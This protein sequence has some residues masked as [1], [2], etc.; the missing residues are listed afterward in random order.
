MPKIR[1]LAIPPDTHGV[2]KFRIINPYTYLQ[3]N[4]SDDFHVDINSTIEDK[5]EEFDN[6]DIIVMHT[7]IHNKVSPERNLERIDWLKKQGKT[8]IVDFDDYWEP[9]MRHPMFIQAK[10]GGIVKAK[11][12]I[13]NAADYLTVTTPIY[14]DTI[15][16]KFRLNN[17]VVFPNAIDETEPQFQSNTIPSDKIRFGWLGGSS[18]MSDIELLTNG[19]SNMYNVVPIDKIQFVLCGFDLRGTI[20]EIN[21]QTKEKTSRPI[22]PE[23]TVW[24]K[25]E[26]IFTNN[27]SVLDINYINFLKSFKEI[28][29]DDKDKP[30]IRRW[31]KEISKYATNYNYFDVSLAPLVPNTFNANKSQLKAIEAGFFKKALIASE[32]APYTIDL[33]SAIEFGGKFNPKGN[34]LLVDPNKNHKQWFQYM[35]R[36]VDNPNMIE[37][38]GNKLYETVKDKY[39][40]RKVTEDRV[41]FLKSIIK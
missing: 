37:D 12:E 19:I 35:K 20:T 23:E 11:I 8:V 9:D 22:K 7:F 41:Q 18:H 21:R 16:N 13:L 36:L 32:T 29:Y 17:I 39:S 24:F 14:R 5:D 2:G 15:H 26:K 25:Y 30:Y 31:T 1:I 6:Y 27:Y 33:I 38:L 4:Y 10:T 34:A 40:L 28:D 3:E